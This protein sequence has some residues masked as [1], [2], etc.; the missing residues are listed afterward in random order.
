MATRPPSGD[1]RRPGP[2]ITPSTPLHP[3]PPSP[4]QPRDLHYP[5]ARLLHAWCLLPPGSRDPGISTCYG[6]WAPGVSPM[7]RTPGSPSQG[8]QPSYAEG[9]QAT[10][11]RQTA[12]QPQPLFLLRV[13]KGWLPVCRIPIISSP[14]FAGPQS[15]LVRQPARPI[16]APGCGPGVGNPCCICYEVWTPGFSSHGRSGHLDTWVL[17]LLWVLHCHAIQAPGFSTCYGI[18]TP[19]TRAL[20]PQWG[21]GTRTPGFSTCYGIRTPGF[22]TCYGIWTPGCVGSPPT[23][24]SRHPMPVISTCYGIWTLDTWVLQAPGPPTP[25]PALAQRTSTLISATLASSTF[26]AVVLPCCSLRWRRM[27]GL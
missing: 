14:Q 21:P 15:L 12:D 25:H 10:A 18:R 11:D 13:G 9:R 5:G 26:S 22:S 6:T 20:H 8:S 17:C 2:P 19:D 23:A 3:P 4:L 24:G 1:P 7:H 27:A 16:L